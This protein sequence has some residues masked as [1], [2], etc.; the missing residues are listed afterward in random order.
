MNK[1]PKK[2]LERLA[3]GLKHFQ[4]I[5]ATAK[6]RDVNES[7]TATILNDIFHEVFG[8]D[9]YFQITSEFAIRGT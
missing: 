2:T 6:N 9:K 8:Y 4:K 3:S 5:V 7:D 1:I